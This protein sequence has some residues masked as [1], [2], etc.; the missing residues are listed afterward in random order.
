VG[1][2]YKWLC[3]VWVGRKNGFVW[4]FLVFD[5]IVGR[6]LNGRE[7]HAGFSVARGK[8]VLEGRAFVFSG[9]WGNVEV[10]TDPRTF[11]ARFSRFPDAAW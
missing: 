1:G 4:Y 5:A 2:W 6:R 3:L 9:K 10:T 7:S 8:G 11:T